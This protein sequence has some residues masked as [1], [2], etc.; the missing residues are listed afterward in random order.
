MGDAKAPRPSAV[1]MVTVS[2]VVAPRI[3]FGLKAWSEEEAAALVVPLEASDDIGALAA[4]LPD[5][6]SITPGAL[7]V[8]LAGAPASRGVLGRLFT[9][10]TPIARH[11]RATAL[12]TR[13]YVSIAAAI[14]DASDLDLV[15][16]YAPI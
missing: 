10:P 2:T 7:V 1:R 9:R 8:T 13:G 5:P 6:G 16:G 4:Q 3:P 15:W 14:D 12:L 11:A